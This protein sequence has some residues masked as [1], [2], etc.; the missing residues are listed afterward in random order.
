[1]EKY[2]KE[3]ESG[4]LLYYSSLGER[5]RRQ[6]AFLESAKLG[7]GGKGYIGSL[8]GISYKTIRKGCSELGSPALFSSVGKGRERKAGGGR[9]FF[10]RNP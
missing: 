1:M 6:Y 3:V 8:L 4:M 2:N 5:S 7:H 9:K 10:L